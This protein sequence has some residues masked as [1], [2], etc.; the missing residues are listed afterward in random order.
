MAHPS[1][2]YVCSPAC[3]LNTPAACSSRSSG[4]P[5]R[6]SATRKLPRGPGRD[7]DHPPDPPA[8]ECVARRPG[9]VPIGGL[10]AL[11]VRVREHQPE[12]RAGARGR[13]GA[14]VDAAVRSPHDVDARACGRGKAGGIARGCFAQFGRRGPGRL[15][16]PVHRVPATGTTTDPRR[17]TG[18]HDRCT[19]IP[20]GHHARDRAARST[21][22]VRL[23]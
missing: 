11:G 7:S 8:L 5:P 14:D 12:H 10:D 21:R 1:C 13:L 4:G 18:R 19:A 17:T 20:L 6:R 23:S 3:S 2:T 22:S 16:A 15:I 9:E